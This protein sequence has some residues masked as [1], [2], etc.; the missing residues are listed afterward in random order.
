[1]SDY[2]RKEMQSMVDNNSW[3]PEK[4][5]LEQLLRELPQLE[6]D[7]ARYRWLKA[8]DQRIVMQIAW[9]VRKACEYTDPDRCVDAARGM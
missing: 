6:A 4:D 1:M 5:A 3:S 7:A 8:T 9:R 2:T